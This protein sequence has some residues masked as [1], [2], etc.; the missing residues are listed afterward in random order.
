M[1]L[2]KEVMLVYGSDISLYNIK[3]K[4]FIKDVSVSSYGGR[5]DYSSS[6]SQNSKKENKLKDSLRKRA[7]ELGAN[8]VID[9]KSS[10]ELGSSLSGNAV[11]IE[12]ECFRKYVK[13]LDNIKVSLVDKTTDHS[14][15]M[16]FLQFLGVLAVFLLLVAISDY[17]F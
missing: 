14:N 8:A 3:V 1:S 9:V 7:L 11:I 12:D 17:H 4:E 2:E 10:G 16:F 6:P 13:N 15:L 5:T